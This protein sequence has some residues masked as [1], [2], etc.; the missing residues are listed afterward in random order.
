VSA[1]KGQVAKVTWLCGDQRVL[2]EEV[3]E[4]TKRIL[5]ASEFD[6]LPLSAESDPELAV[7]DSV[8]QYSLDPEGNRLTLVRQADFIKDWSP[9]AKWLQD[10]K[11]M[12]SNYLLLVSD[13]ADY[14]TTDDLKNPEILPHIELIRKRG[15]TVRCS[16]PSQAEVIAWIKRNSTFTDYSANFLY[17]RCGSD[18][19]AVANVCKKSKLFRADPG[20]QVISQ[21]SD[22]YASQSFADSLIYQNKKQALLELP[23]IPITDYSRVV[24]QLYSRLD[25]LYALHKAAPN[26]NTTREL[27]EATG[28]KM[29]LV[30]KYLQAAKTYDMTKVTNCRNILTVADDALQR[31]ATDGVMEL[32]VSLW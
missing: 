21:L 16:M 29:F 11:F 22:E 15:K 25:T 10:A 28:I 1:D 32:L 26:F 7:W 23:N 31:N 2:A 6:Y 30:T 9:L 8:Y 3:V 27:S 24:G 18:L 17:E 13:H 20:S 14:P 4:E 5:N 19:S 12:S